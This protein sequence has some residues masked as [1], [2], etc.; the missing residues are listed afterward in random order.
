M[1]NKPPITEQNGHLRKI[2]TKGSQMFIADVI[3]NGA[4]IL[5]L[6]FQ[7][8][9]DKKFPMMKKAF[10]SIFYVPFK[11]LQKPIEWTIDKFGRSIEGEEGREIRHAQTDEQRLD[12]LLNSSYHYASAIGVGWGS[13]VATEKCLSYY[14]KSKALPGRMWTAV[15]LPVHVGL[16]AFLGAPFMKPVT[17]SVKDL[18]KK[19]MIASGGWSEEKA[20]QD[21]RFTVAYIIPNYLTLVPTVGMMNSLYKAE[22]KGFLKDVGKKDWLGQDEHHFATTDKPLKEANFDLITTNILKL[23][24]AI[25]VISSP[26]SGKTAAH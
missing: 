19:I 9:I 20:E 2:A 3:G 24:K 14:M 4:E 1:S 15:D 17:G 8:D 18:T 7:D 16:T 11:F 6:R 10:K 21:A 23:A 25:G 12:G 26:G 5:F 22:S 13:L